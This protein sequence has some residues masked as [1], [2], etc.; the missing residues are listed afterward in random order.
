M[1]LKMTRYYHMCS[2]SLCQLTINSEWEMFPTF[3]SS[4]PS[5]GSV[6]R[7]YIWKEQ[8]QKAWCLIHTFSSQGRWHS[9]SAITAHL[10]F[11]CELHLCP[12]SILLV[13][14]LISICKSSCLNIWYTAP[15]ML[16]IFLVFKNLLKFNGVFHYTI[17]HPYPQ[18]LHT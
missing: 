8:R 12:L 1:H 17:S 11:L 6:P 3:Q 16:L 7:T 9:F 15:C 18:A 5:L 10:R 14:H 4:G 13:G 2:E